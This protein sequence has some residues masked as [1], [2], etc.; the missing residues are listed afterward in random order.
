[1]AKD[2]QAE[3]MADMAALAGP[4]ELPENPGNYPD[5]GSLKA[6]QDAVRAVEEPDKE[7]PEPAVEAAAEPETAPEPE[8]AAEEEPPLAAAPETESEI[9]AL[10]RELDFVRLALQSQQPQAPQQP[11]QP[12]GIDPLVAQA[13][14]PFQVNEEQ[15]ADFLAGGPRAAQHFTNALQS[16]VLMGAQLAEQRLRAELDARDSQRAAAQQQADEAQRRQEQFWSANAD[17]K[18]Y[19]RVVRSVTADVANEQKRAQ[20]TWEQAQAEIARRSRAELS[21]MGIKLPGKPVAQAT[22]STPRLKPAVA[23]MGAGR[24]GNGGAKLSPQEKL[25]MSLIER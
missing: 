19:E 10:R 8:P 24:T 6:E 13:L 11:A 5:D 14:A 1:M 23:E 18:P 21:A 9:A 15:L 7:K 17:L 2:A 16:A 22:R 3:L 20:R 25:M 4:L 12:Q